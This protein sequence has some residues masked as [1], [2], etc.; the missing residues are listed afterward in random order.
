VILVDT[1]VLVAAADAD[2]PDCEACIRALQ[3]APAPRLVTGLVIA[4]ASYMLA[5]NGGPGAEAPF[6]RSFA[7]GFLEVAPITA[8][9]LVRA[10]ALVEQYSDLPLDA[11]DATTVAVAERLGVSHVA[12]LDSDF[13]VVRPAH[14]E[15]FTI[16]P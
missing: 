7:E 13:R 9:D 5:R 6:L 4:E 8:A 1:S 15:A 12:T 10:A 2:D 14:G 11:S 16:T 3:E